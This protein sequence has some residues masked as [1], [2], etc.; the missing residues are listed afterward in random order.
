VATIFP[1]ADLVSLVGGDAVRV[2]TL[3]PPRASPATWEVTPSQLRSVAAAEGVVSVGGG[4]DAWLERGDGLDQ[5][6]HRLRL[7]DGLTLLD[8]SH[9]H[10]AGASGDPH[11]W[12][13]PILVRDRLVP[14]FVEFLT[15]IVPAAAPGL[16]QRAERLG[17]SLTA[18]DGE[19][20]SALSDAAGRRFVATHHAW[21]YFSQRYGLESLGSLYE[22][23]GH[24][25]S[26]RGLA[27]LIEEARSEGLTAVLSEPQLAGTAALAL[28]DELG[29][30][31]VVVDPL[32]GAMLEGRDGYL[33][34]MRF[35]AR[36]FR[37]ALGGP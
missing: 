9:D 21:A 8:E 10:G 20:R 14:R 25:P 26:A 15:G 33:Q 17:D 24:E 2:E 12:L 6:P 31:V 3:L 35:N 5:V 18:L 32:G 37:R 36:A 30:V 23:P 22:R 34:M 28:A 13:D 1:V 16:R 11:V 19:I 7:T 27:R 4:L 29:A